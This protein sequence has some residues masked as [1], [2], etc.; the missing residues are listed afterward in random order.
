MRRTS[1]AWL[2]VAA[3][4]MVIAASTSPAFR[5]D[6]LDQPTTAWG[7]LMAIADEPQS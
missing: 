2:V 6:L 3:S 4:V 7:K 1:E 5:A